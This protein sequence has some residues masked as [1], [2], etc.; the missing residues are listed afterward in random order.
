MSRL[1]RLSAAAQKPRIRH[2]ERVALSTVVAERLQRHWRTVNYNTSLFIAA[3]TPHPQ[4]VIVAG[5][6]GEVLS[7]E[8]RFHVW[9]LD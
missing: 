9:E 7:I 5:N 1:F 6:K 4:E 8:Q 3:S 2:H